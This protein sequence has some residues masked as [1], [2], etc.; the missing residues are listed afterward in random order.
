MTVLKLVSVFAVIFYTF[1]GQM[2]Q[3]QP[4]Y[5]VS[6]ISQISNL[7]LQSRRNFGSGYYD[8]V[9][10]RTY[11]AWNGPAMDVYINA[12]NHDAGNWG[13]PV[14]LVDWNDGGQFAY[15]DYTVM[16]K[17][18]DGRIGI[19][20]FDHV[21][22]ATL[23]R[24][25]NPHSL[26]GPWT[27][28]VISTDRN[29]YPM[30]VV[31][32]GTTYLFYSRNDNTTGTNA[33]RTYRMIRS[34]DSGVSWSSPVT[35]IDSGQ[36]ADNFNEVYAQGVS[37]KNNRIYI[38]WTM[39]GGAI[40]DA[41]S[42]NLYIGYYN[43]SDNQIYTIRNES[44]GTVANGADL[45]SF[46]VRQVGPYQLGSDY[47]LSHP[48]VNSQ[49]FQADDG[50]LHLA[51]GETEQ[52]SGTPRVIYGHWNGN[53]WNFR[54]VANGTMRFMDMYKSGAND[55]E[56]LYTTADWSRMISRKTID[57]GLSFSL[58]YDRVTPFGGSSANRVI[59]ANFVE[60]R[61]EVNAIAG[62]TETTASTADNYVGS[63]PMIQVRW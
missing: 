48:I 31:V 10:N 53:S 11:V 26:G 38:T 39:A 50:T 37:V 24:S 23:L 42:R 52:S 57:G 15:H 2:A 22:S 41:A 6:N 59:Y 56:I 58:L 49:A 16:Q 62:T 40:H 61:R 34:P 44:R 1:F 21:G 55:F 47:A 17:L 45:N 36:T 7:S 5:T 4:N 43:T 8:A 63:Y 30:P 29:A 51:F 12:Y 60:N 32:G 28:Q 13:I 9:S 27:R 20:I 25:A 18:P 14:K 3:A 46:L 33:Y 19:F 35:V 54:T